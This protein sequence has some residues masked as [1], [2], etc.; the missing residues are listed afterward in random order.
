MGL[1]LILASIE[2]I[3]WSFCLGFGAFA[4]AFLFNEDVSFN[5]YLVISFTPFSDLL[6]YSSVAITTYFI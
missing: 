4:S 3:F 1:V 6:I 2:N 5:D